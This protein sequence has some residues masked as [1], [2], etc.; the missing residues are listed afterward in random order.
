[1]E[2]RQAIE[3]A[4]I[5]AAFDGPDAVD[6]IASQINAMDFA[7][8]DL[9]AVW[10]AMEALSDADSA[11]D[12]VLIVQHMSES[13]RVPES[14]G[15]PLL[16]G[17]MENR[18]E[19]AHIDHYCEALKKHAATD[20]AHLLGEQLAGEPLI[21]QEVI[22]GYISKLDQIQRGRK[23][24]IKTVADAVR[25]LQERKANPRAIHRTGL[26]SLDDTL[27]GGLRDGQSI[28]IGGR[29]G[30]G[31]SVLMV[32]IGA[33]VA[34]SGTGVLIVSL[35]MM[36]EELIDRLS[37]TI[38]FDR[39]PQLPLYFIDSTSDLGT[40]QSLVRVACRRYKIGLIVI[41]YL[42]LMEVPSSKHDSRERQIATISR[43][44]KRMAL[45]LQKPVIVG[46]QLNRESTKKG[47]P[48]LAD[49]R[50]SGSIEQDA[51]IVL[52]LSASD[53]GPE[54]LLQVAKQRGGGTGEI[55]LKLDGPRFAF[56]TEESAYSYFE[57]RFGN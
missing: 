17:L 1:M 46:S 20:D 49:L 34:Q 33:A 6:R 51:D 41:D 15:V 24:E 4:I 32:Q 2:S 16:A 25:G 37:R 53:D 30:A 45:D 14:I 31:K 38:D 29:P 8:R 19:S 44:L 28:V 22:D 21:N 54:T 26:K 43:R 5:S 40:I 18:W 10:N 57:R 52:L 55:T 7:N 12:P 39:L 50:E 35:E 56:T 11:L 42:Q 23:D 3:T 48:T 9:R 36:K 27:R 47:K 13:G